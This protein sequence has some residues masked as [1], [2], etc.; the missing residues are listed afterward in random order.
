MNS[1]KPNTS[2]LFVKIKESYCILYCFDNCCYISSVSI[3]DDF[4]SMVG[5]RSSQK[6]T[7]ADGYR[8]KQFLDWLNPQV[9]LYNKKKQFA[10]F[11]YLTVFSHIQHNATYDLLKIVTKIATFLNKVPGLNSPESEAM[12]HNR[13]WQ[14]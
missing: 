4:H 11:A 13:P 7:R 2:C 10:S 1:L 12:A 5:S 9:V 3:A 14:R 6:A 8:Q